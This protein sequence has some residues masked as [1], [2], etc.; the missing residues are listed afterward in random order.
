MSKKSSLRIGHI[1]ARETK[2]R[3]YEVEHN[4]ETGEIRV[5]RNHTFNL[6][7]GISPDNPELEDVAMAATP[8]EL[9]GEWVDFLHPY[10]DTPERYQTTRSL[11]RE[12]FEGEDPR[13]SQ[14][15]KVKKKKSVRFKFKENNN[16]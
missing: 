13:K 3:I 7:K 10:G 14:K 11:Y 4:E 15:K 5:W 1:K 12:V 9:S 2:R 8:E 16:G 6:P